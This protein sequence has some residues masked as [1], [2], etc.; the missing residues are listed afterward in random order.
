MK[1]I[2][3]C[4]SA[5]ALLV[6][7]VSVQRQAVGGRLH[8]ASAPAENDRPLRLRAFGVQHLR[9]S[10][11]AAMGPWPVALRPAHLAGVLAEPGKIARSEEHTSELQSLRHI[12]CRLLLE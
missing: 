9:R 7:G 10:P 2:N 3:Y 1:G 6:G 11:A 4:A 12:V 8:R 5:K